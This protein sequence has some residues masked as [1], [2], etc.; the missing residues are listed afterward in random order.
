MTIEELQGEHSVLMAAYV[1]EIRSVALKAEVRT[2]RYGGHSTWFCL[3]QGGVLVDE[4]Q[5]LSGA[6]RKF[7]EVTA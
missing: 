6:V 4:T 3:Y 7:N 2:D 1:D 5:S